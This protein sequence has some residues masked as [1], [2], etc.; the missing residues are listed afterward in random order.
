MAYSSGKPSFSKFFSGAQIT[1]YA[2]DRRC[3]LPNVTLFDF[4]RKIYSPLGIKVVSD[5]NSYYKISRYYKL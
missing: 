2:S 3:Y 4:K 1:K 5:Q